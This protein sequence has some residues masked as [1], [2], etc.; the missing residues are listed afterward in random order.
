MT[1][2][3]GKII[4]KYELLEPLGSG[5]MATVYRA[6]QQPLGRTVAVKVLHPHLDEQ[7][8]FRERFLREA[9]AVASL[10]HS[11]IVQMYDFDFQSGVCYMAMEFLDGE[12]LENRLMLLREQVGDKPAPLPLDQAMRIV[13]QITQ[14]LEFA[15]KQHVI[16]RDIKPANIMQTAE[17]RI[18]LTD[19]GIATILHETRLTVEGGTSGTPTY[20]SPEQ[21][22]GGR[23]DARSDLYSLGAVL[24]QLVTGRLPFEAETLYG[25][26]M[27]HIN[28]TPAPASQINPNVPL[29]VEQIIRKAMVKD[30]DE[31]YQSA[32][33]FGADLEAVLAGRQVT[34]DLPQAPVPAPAGL[35]RY[36]WWLAGAAAMLIFLTI[37]AGLFFN[38]STPTHKTTMPAVADEPVS[39]PLSDEPDF[40]VVSMV[41]KPDPDEPFSDTFARAGATWPIS[42][43]PVARQIVDGAYEITVTM[44]DRATSTIPKNL[45]RYERFSYTV[46]ATLRE[47]Q[48]ES[49][50]GLIFHRENSENFNVFAINGLQQWSIWRLKAGMWQELRRLPNGET[51]TADPAIE[52]LGETNQLRVEAEL[53]TFNLFVNDHLL[54]QIT[55]PDVPATGGVV[56]FYVASTRSSAEAL[57]RVQFDN[58]ALAPLSGLSHPSM[59]AEE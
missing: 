54:T 26:I 41:A 52:P 12:S 38:R 1:T 48:P 8:D 51:W 19:F 40:G 5:G 4:G 29:V 30:P 18:V 37:G 6:I 3:T 56:G 21:A 13:L 15:H 43:A 42:K 25:L 10:R 45:S 49:G 39:A 14:A 17:G 35:A 20:M 57:A 23:G 31:R 36:S 46:D 55:D 16:H 11:H 2:L 53:G 59:A 32:A 47:G 33:E 58:L 44:A 7:Q 22:L 50:Y 28:D 9:K 24:Y 34:V 27:A